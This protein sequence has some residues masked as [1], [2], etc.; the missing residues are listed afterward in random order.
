MTGTAYKTFVEAEEEARG[1]G[2]DR[3]D[4]ARRA[5]RALEPRLRRM[6]VRGGGAVRLDGVELSASERAQPIVVDPGRHSLQADYHHR[7]PVIR[8]VEVLEPGKTLVVEL[9]HDAAPEPSVVLSPEPDEPEQ[10]LGAQR[11]AAISSGAL[12]VVGLAVGT[13]LALVAK[14][15]Y[16]GAAC[17]EDGLCTSDGL[18]E[19][20]AAIDLANGATGGFVVGGALGAVGIVLWFTAP[21]DDVVGSA[22]LWPSFTLGGL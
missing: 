18:A 12:G 10:G 20:D 5:A 22:S 7:A 6:F 2:D 16:D 14:N 21:T 17:T 1:A 8:T 15:R 19:R 11:I 9:P 3:E 13:A 4:K